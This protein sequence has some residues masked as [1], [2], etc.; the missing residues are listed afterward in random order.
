MTPAWVGPTI[1]IALVVIAASFLLIGGVTLAIGLE[2]RRQSRALKA[3]IAAFSTE[4]RSVT[5]RLRRELEGF[6]ELSADART[7][8]KGAIEVMDG[9]LRDLDALAEVLQQEAEETAL[10]VASFVRTVRRSGHILGAAR[11][12]VLGRRGSKG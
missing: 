3:Q 1:A 12:S 7:R 6:A 5:G 4:A 8:I 10:D 11:R 9:R 2:L